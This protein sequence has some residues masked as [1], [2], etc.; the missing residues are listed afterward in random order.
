ML[1]GA[2][3]C[4]AQRREY[5][6][7][8][9]AYSSTAALDR[10]VTP[11]YLTSRTTP[12]ECVWRNW[13]NVGTVVSLDQLIEMRAGW[14]AAGKR[15]VLACGAFDL[16]HPGHVRLL[17]QAR[18]LGDVVVAAVEDDAAVRAAA[19]AEKDRAGK[20]ARTAVSRPVVPA[21]ERAEILACLSAV[22]FV[23]QMSGITA[24]ECIDR[25]RP[26]IYVHGGAFAEPLES[27]RE[28]LGSDVVE[29]ACNFVSIPLEPGFSTALLIERIQQVRQ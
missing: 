18:S 3:R 2:S 27:L 14:R 24:A 26:D 29:G 22:D 21:V 19:E 13:N 28:S 8:R 9:C 10:I 20:A 7:L 6:K 23:T 5:S 11:L 12:G 1:L 17:E 16:L 15:L 4:R 25:L